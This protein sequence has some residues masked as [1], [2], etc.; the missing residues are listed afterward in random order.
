ME[1]SVAVSSIAEPPATEPCSTNS[2]SR[3]E[4]DSAAECRIGNLQ[5]LSKHIEE[6]TQH[7]IQCLPYQ[8]MADSPDAI[9][10]TDRNGLASVMSCK[11]NDCGQQITFATSTKTTGLTGKAHWTNNLA[12]I[13]GQMAVG[14]GF[15][16]LE[17][18]MSVLCVPVM[19]NSSFVH[20]EQVIGK[21]W[22][23]ILQESM[24][25]AGKEEK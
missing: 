18:S 16:S 24:I 5:L 9:T 25:A 21:W 6:V 12:A 2:H 8:G 22:W 14:G 15:N 13:W 23:T 7:V 10:I 20:T 19:T 17:E 11:F 4:H 1:P 3:E